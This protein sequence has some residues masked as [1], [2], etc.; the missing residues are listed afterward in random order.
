MRIKVD[1]GQLNTVKLKMDENSNELLNEIDIL[2][3]KVRELQNVWQGE[4]ANI[5]YMKF[6][7]YIT[8]LKSI[9]ATYST[10]SS[11]IERANIMY[12][13]ADL[14][15]KQKINDVRMNN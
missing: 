11:F 2:S 10:M 8:K 4:E 14:S 15:L 5:F 9:P 6:N 13:E 1:H 7:N 3:N 12:K